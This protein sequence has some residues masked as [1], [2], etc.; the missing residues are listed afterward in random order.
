MKQVVFAALVLF[1]T[2]A[3]E[4][5]AQEKK[6]DL[7][8]ALQGGM[9][10]VDLLKLFKPDKTASYWCAHGRAQPRRREGKRAVL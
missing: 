9:I 5:T 10:V 7:D 1:L 2:Y 6:N 3:H 4:A 8:R